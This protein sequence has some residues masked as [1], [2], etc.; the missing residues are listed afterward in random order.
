M[1]NEVM[2]EALA[3]IEGQVE[4]K[5]AKMPEGMTLIGVKL[6]RDQA[7]A[8]RFIEAID[9]D[10]QTVG[11]AI[12]MRNG[13]I[14]AGNPLFGRWTNGMPKVSAMH[15][16]KCAQC[17][18]S[19]PMPLAV[20]EAKD[21]ARRQGIE[22]P[23]EMAGH[24]ILQK[25]GSCPCGQKW[26]TDDDG[27]KAMLNAF[28]AE[29]LDVLSAADRVPP[30]MGP[31]AFSVLP[32]GAVKTTDT[33]AEWQ[34][35]AEAMARAGKA[36]TPFKKDQGG[37]VVIYNPGLWLGYVEDYNSTNLFWVEN[38]KAR[39]GRHAASSSFNPRS[40]DGL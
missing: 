10:W 11:L 21:C 35:L 8:G 38:G 2:Q 31:Q 7:R 28:A 30:Y 9:R 18:K 12:A 25:Y 1:S 26:R 27:E 14:V 29:V 13:H 32:L 6:D 22:I 34:W 16:V 17:G 20:W 40:V 15:W 4:V 36:V 37:D 5:P 19:T 33:A 24:E 3:G 39:H 23:R